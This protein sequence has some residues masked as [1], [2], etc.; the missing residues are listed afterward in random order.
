[1]FGIKNF[2]NKKN[3][4]NANKKEENLEIINEAM[5]KEK[6]DLELLKAME[7]RANRGKTDVLKNS[8][9]MKQAKEISEALKIQNPFVG[10]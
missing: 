7:I 5:S 4:L 1:M 10:K 3:N 2:K 6:A 9:A 8:E